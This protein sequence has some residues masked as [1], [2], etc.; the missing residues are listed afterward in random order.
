MSKRLFSFK[1]EELVVIAAVILASVRKDIAD[2]AAFSSVFTVEFLDAI[3]AKI[4]ACKNLIAVS[5]IAKELKLKTKEVDE[6]SAAFRTKLNALE[7]YFKF[8]ADQLDIQVSD[9]G[10]KSVRLNIS[11]GNTEGVVSG[12]RMV[13]ANVKRN[14][15]ALE[16]KGMKPEFLTAF[17]AE[18]NGIEELNNKQVLLKN[19]MSRHAD[20]NMDI[21]NELWND[22]C[23]I[24]DGAKAIYRGVDDVKL[25]DYNISLL[26]KRINAEGRDTT[27][28]TDNP[29]PIV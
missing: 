11:S 20:V 15:A 4:E 13:L 12:L 18:I 22:I 24:T 1:I 8:A 25:K 23:V 7:A 28:S 26:R 9:V 17:E 21:Y 29:N 3:A 2:F 27:N 19:E 5:S 14:K 6:K 16:A 10:I